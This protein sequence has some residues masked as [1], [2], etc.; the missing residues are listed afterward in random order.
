MIHRQHFAGLKSVRERPRHHDAILE[1]VGNA[2]RRAHVVLEHAEFARLRIAHQIDPADMRMNSAR[3]PYADHLAPEMRARIDE[4]PRNPLVLEDHLLAVHVHQE[5]IQRHHA[6]RKPAIDSLP[7]R[8]RDN[9]RDQ[10]ERKQT[11]G[12]LPVAVYRER[13]SLDQ[14]RQIGKL[15]PLLELA[16]RHRGQLLKQ[17]GVLRPRVPWRREH[18]VVKSARVVA[19]KKAAVHHRYWDRSHCSLLY[20]PGLS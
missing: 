10:V 19:L 6:L 9:A 4:R 17:F 12:S 13:D 15:P 11:L 18:L 1:H 8:M 20:Q 16:W 3:H 5:E 7:F 14:E 2:A